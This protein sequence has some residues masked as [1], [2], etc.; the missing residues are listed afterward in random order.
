MVD[1]DKVNIS[2]LNQEDEYGN[3]LVEA[4]ASIMDVNL[5]KKLLYI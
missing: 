5:F 1:L 4:I 3:K 2:E